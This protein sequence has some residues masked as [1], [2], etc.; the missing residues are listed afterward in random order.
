MKAWLER[1]TRAQLIVAVSVAVIGCVWLWAA[2]SFWGHYRSLHQQSQDLIPRIARLTG[3]AES[4]A[5]LQA[6]SE[7]AHGQLQLLVYGD[8]GDAGAMMQQQVRQVMER[9]GLTVA[10]SQ[11]LSPRVE[12]L[13][14]RLQLDINATGS[15]EAL[16]IALQELRDLRPLVMID[17][18]QAQ[19]VRSR[20]RRGAASSPEQVVTLRIRL[21][22]LR[23]Q[24]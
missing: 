15:I 24:P 17:S 16:E 21:S 9:A 14:T 10:G 23:L 12:A 4:E 3:L 5:V 18:L 6:A 7:Q 8:A 2:V 19:P 13:F 11:I 1:I 22:S 20:A